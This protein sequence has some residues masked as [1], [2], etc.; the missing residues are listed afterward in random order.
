M[1]ITRH[2]VETLVSRGLA[3]MT[4]PPNM[5]PSHKVVDAPLIGNGDL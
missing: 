2:E 5:I 4:E 1:T 3:H